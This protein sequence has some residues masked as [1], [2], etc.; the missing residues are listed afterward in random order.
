M[1]L[2]EQEAFQKHYQAGKVAFER[3]L[4]RASIEA[5]E[6]ACSLV[7]GTSRLGGEAQIW[8]VTAYQAANE[9]EK[10]IALCEKLLRHPFPETSKQAKRLL[11]IIKAPALKRPP[12]WMTQIPDLRNIE[13]SK[14]DNRYV[15]LQEKPRIKVKK[16]EPEPIDPSLINRKD[17]NFVTLALVLILLILLGFAFTGKV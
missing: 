10:A 8:L 15:P 16:V 6:A 9:Q 17:N 4:Y 1:N 3:G 12:E 5:L 11:Y 14:P 7:R 2:E 13:D